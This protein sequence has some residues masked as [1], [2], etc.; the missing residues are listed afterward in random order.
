MLDIINSLS[1]VLGCKVNVQKQFLQQKKW[2]M[3]GPMLTSSS[4]QNSVLNLTQSQS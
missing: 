4:F 3:E 2:N 1:K